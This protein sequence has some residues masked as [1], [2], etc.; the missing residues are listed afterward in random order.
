MYNTEAELGKAIKDSKIPR[1]EFYV[2]TKV[3]K[4]V[5]DIPSALDASLKKLGLDYVDLYV[6]PAT[7]YAYARPS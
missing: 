2:T 3:H 4:N 6:Q 1:E 5:K 7:K